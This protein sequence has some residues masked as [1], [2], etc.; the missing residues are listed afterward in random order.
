MKDQALDEL[1]RGDA[2]VNG[3][4]SKRAQAALAFFRAS[5]LDPMLL[6]PQARLAK[7]KDLDG[8]DFSSRGD[9]RVVAM[10]QALQD[11]PHDPQLLG[12]LAEAYRSQGDMYRA[13]LYYKR[14]LRRVPGDDAMVSRL[15]WV[16]GK[17]TA[18]VY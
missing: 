1:R 15:A 13:A 18:S 9:R 14:Y 6:E 7:L 2:L 16:V 11:D 12:R 4:K 8:I 5:L 17:D 10:K 3:G